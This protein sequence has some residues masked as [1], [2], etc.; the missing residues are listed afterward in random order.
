LGDKITLDRLDKG[1][2]RTWAVIRKPQGGLA[3]GKM[4]TLGTFTLDGQNLSFNWNPQ[5]QAG[6]KPDAL[7]FCMLKVEVGDK[8]EICRLSNPVTIEALKLDKF[9]T[10]KRELPRLDASQLP[11]IENISL[12]IR[13]VGFPGKV[14]QEPT[15]PVKAGKSKSIRVF[16]GSETE[17]V[18]LQME[19]TFSF[20]KEKEGKREILI[21]CKEWYLD[22]KIS[23]D[24]AVAIARPVS[25]TEM[26]KRISEHDKK[27]E[28]FERERKKQH[29]QL[30][31]QR[32]SIIA[33]IAEAQ[34][35]INKLQNGDDRDKEAAKA[36]NKEKGEQE[37]ILQN[38]E[39]KVK[40]EKKKRDDEKEI[41]RQTEETLKIAN[42]IMQKGRLEFRVLVPVDDELVELYKTAQ[43]A[44]ER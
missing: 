26:K 12:E 21:K 40:S 27:S 17:G 20:D 16:G 32:P 18:F 39:D 38:L 9:P 14:T 37:A 43:F 2:V 6:L 7:R 29:N 1:D 33:K 5:V 28:V 22:G 34:K 8:S 23:I 35:W 24:D 10:V 25:T 11:D 13:P 30:E 19:I 15:E 3:G 36:R 41:V 4:E 42:E 44:I 31:E